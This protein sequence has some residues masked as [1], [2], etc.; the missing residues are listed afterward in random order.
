MKKVIP[1][2]ATAFALAVMPNTVVA[3]TSATDAQIYA[4]IPIRNLGPGVTG[5]RVSDFAVN[6]NNF[7][8]YYVATSSGGLWKTT[9]A[10][11]TW[12]PI[13][14]NQ[15]SYSLGDVTLDPNN[16]NVVWVGSGENNSQRSVAYG[17]GIYKS[18]DAGKTWKN[19]GLKNSEHIGEIL[20]DPRN[21]D[22]VYAASQGPLWSK[23]GDRGL[24]KTI[25]GGKTWENV[26]NISEHTGVSDIAFDPKNPDVIYA[27]SYQRRRH[28]WTLING[29]PESA[30]H[31]STDGGKTWQKIT[32]GLPGGDLGRI[33]IDVAPSSANII[34]AIV[35][36]PNDKGGFYRSTDYGASWHKQSSYVSGSPQYYQE[37]VVD[38]K[39]P[40]RVYSLDTYMMVTE[41]GGKNFTRAGEAHKHV[42]NHA[43]W[44]NPNNTNHLI[45]GS[46]G[47]V[48]ESFDRAK[49]WRFFDN[50]P[51]TQFY[52]VTVDND[53]PFYNVFGGTQD[54]ASLG[55]P[56]R[57]T[58]NSGIRNSDW[59]YTQFGDGFKT[60]I[61]PTDAN[62]IYSQYQYGGLAR[63]DKRSG[64]RV[65]MQP[66][67]PDVNE[68]QR[69]NWNSPLL[70]SPHNNERLYYASQRVFRT[71]DRGDTWQAVSP[72]L[73]RNVDRNKLEVMDTVWG[74]DTVAKNKST[75]FY[76][77]VVSLTE[78][79][80]TEG[81]L[82]AGTDDGLIQYTV[83][84]GDSWQKAKWPKKLPENSYVSDLEASLFDDSTVF[85]TFDN[86]KKGD[87]T[88][89][90]YRSD[91]KGK[92]W[93]NITG[94][95]PKRGSVY[96]IVQDHVNKDL[97]FV[98]TEFGVFF[99]QTGGE[100]WT[101]LKGNMPTIAI[102]DLEIQRR[103]N[104]LAMASFGRGFFVFD[105]YTPL[106]ESAKAV[107]SSAAT[108]FPVRKAIQFI[109]SDP[110]GL[111]GKSMQ[112]ASFYFAENPAY[113]AVFSYYIG[114]DF[115]SLKTKRQKKDAKL[116]QE[117]KPVYYPSWDELKEEDLELAS[118]LVFTVK[119]MEG[120]VVRRLTAPAKKGFN[121]IAW[122]LRYP[123]FGV[124]S[125]NVTKDSGPFVV[126]GKY[127]VS[128]SKVVN[129]VDTAYEG[130]QSFE[131]VAFENR[132]F[133][134]NDR[135]ADLA[136]DMKAGQLASA[137]NGV[138]NHIGSL[139][140]RIDN[141]G[142]SATQTLSAPQVLHSQ[143]A[144]MKRELTEIKYLLNGNRVI[145]K[146]AE[147]TPTSVQGYIGYLQWSRSE[148]TGPV[149]GQQKLRYNR[150]SEGFDVVYQRTKALTELVEKLE[151]QLKGLKSNFL[152]NTGI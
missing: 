131:V 50:M 151:G 62:I 118:H 88:P 119:D 146:R 116:R 133:K 121:R 25:D 59:L 89:Y 18:V 144:Q 16:T 126:P 123:G 36:L 28:V 83:N 63:F 111:P 1:F 76:G 77:S 149:S 40:H 145:A 39:N 125:K 130:S 105:D 114:E 10:G 73:S 15:A 84:G 26:L 102:R 71:N 141:I 104:D 53:L 135:N 143:V 48:Y 137:I 109:E 7:S 142:Y 139:A 30:I 134:S 70:I 17:D 100:S 132:T 91:N 96:T 31:K 99:S 140:K 29:G 152:P 103:E 68:A 87:F 60:V 107:K 115:T 86:H 3:K 43:L 78:S 23:G 12:K 129:G 5:G 79:P 127:Q 150:A 112:G 49:N 42:D 38:P 32:K 75:S 85:A 35:E 106:R 41:D 72:D 90:V 108:L 95:L 64:E 9:N 74:V 6:P 101:Q 55:A 61:D 56:H 98:G 46:D 136:F 27:T 45:V 97:L 81:V 67:T 57:T 44:I 8:E 122:D 82:F 54:N 110:M 124:V 52:K 51:L 21:S 148:S 19:M 128:V 22:V 120:N 20:V 113:G 80:I 58:N 117:G 14:D 13:F 2:I 92:S 147:P 94:N 65:Q 93:K 34:Y 4:N 24:F 37:I 69:F 11:T 66:V 33:G 47:G 138:Q